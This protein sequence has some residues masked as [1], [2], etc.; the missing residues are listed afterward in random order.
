M[1][2]PVVLL[3][4]LTL[5]ILFATSLFFIIRA[6]KEAREASQQTQEIL[7]ATLAEQSKLLDKTI[8][9]A[10]SKDPLAFQAIQAMGLT[11]ETI[12]TSDSP[13]DLAAVAKYYGEE[14]DLNEREL[15]LVESELG[16]RGF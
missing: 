15:A 2:F 16:I 1:S 13:E 7:R 6:S 10:T 12:S 9:I 8:A 11:Q 3:L 5:S 4:C 14:D